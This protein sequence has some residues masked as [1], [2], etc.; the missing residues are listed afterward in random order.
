MRTVKEII[1]YGNEHSDFIPFAKEA[2]LDF[3]SFEEAQP[4]LKEDAA[5]DDWHQPTER[6]VERAIDALTEYMGRIALDKAVNHRSISASRSIDKI[7]AWLWLAGD[8]EGVELMDRTAYENYGAPKLLTVCERLGIDWRS[9]LGDAEDIAI[10]EAQAR[11][12]ICPACR[13]GA[14]SGCGE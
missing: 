4:W 5:P 7:R 9:L 2:L 1:A 12:E 14:M 13:V 8:D 11:G 10:F 6:T 3:L